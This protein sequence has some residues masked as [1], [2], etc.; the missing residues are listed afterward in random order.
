MRPGGRVKVAT[1]TGSRCSDAPVTSQVDTIFPNS[2]MLN[3]FSA[4]GPM[5]CQAT[6]LR[7]P[8]RGW[9]AGLPDA[10]GTGAQG[11]IGSD[12]GFGLAT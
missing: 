2:Q 4:V 12:T 1:S 5:L 3:N 9:R 6:A 8:G 7:R 11:P 10:R